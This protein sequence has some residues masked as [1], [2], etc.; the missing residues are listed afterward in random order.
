MRINFKISKGYSIMWLVFAVIYAVWMVFFLKADTY[1]SA[2]TGIKNSAIYTVWAVASCIIMLVYIVLLNRY[3]YADLGKSDRLFA[4][5]TLVFGCVFITWYGFFKNPFEFTA[6]MIGLEY[7]WHFKMWGVFAPVSIFINTIYM[8]RKYN[9]KSSAGIISCSIGC[10]AMF[11]TINV[12]SA[13][14]ELIL[15]SLRCMAHWSGALIFAFCCAA[16]VVIFLLHMCK[17]KNIR[18]IVAT[19]VFCGVLVAMLVL[20]ATIGKDGFIESLPMWAV[21]ILL[22][23]MNFTNVF[24]AKTEKKQLAGVSG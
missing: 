3:L 24:K 21:Y 4:L 1:P 9:F 7:P 13:G 18:Y 15:T 23:L 5:V 10:A 12:P 19:V 14:E 16:P 22:F 11:V 20:L 17:T 2:D 6:S 8:Y